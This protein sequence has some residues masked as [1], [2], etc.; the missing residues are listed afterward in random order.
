MIC[1]EA[2]KLVERLADG[3]A[4]PDERAAVEGHVQTCESCRAHL[5][6]LE[7]IHGAARQMG[8]SLPQPDE[9]Y[10]NAFPERVLERVR[11]VRR[12]PTAGAGSW[13]LGSS[14][15]LLRFGALAATVV[16]GV[17]LLFTALRDDLLLPAPE[18]RV[19]EGRAAVRPA[20]VPSPSLRPGS[21]DQD[22]VDAL[23]DRA[24]EQE[25]SPAVTSEASPEEAEPAFEKEPRP[26]SPESE[27]V[28]A[29]P[30]SASP[31][32]SRRRLAE[33]PRPEAPEES[34]EQD[35]LASAPAPT[36]EP[37]GAQLAEAPA[38]GRASDPARRLEVAPAGA[39]VAREWSVA[40]EPGEPLD[41]A[42]ETAAEAVVEFRRL[43]AAHS[44]VGSRKA[45]EARLDSP[46]PL[47]SPRT[48]EVWRSY[49]ER[50]GS[51]P[52]V[53]DAR[54][55][56][57][58]CSVR[59]HDLAPE[60]GSRERALSDLEA[61]LAVEGDTERAAEMKALAERLRSGSEP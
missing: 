6:A 7:S 43:V 47:L 33:T 16:I 55:E 58:W 3:E 46:Q 15:S 49:L 50:F 45:G 38:P 8:G 10:W 41:D 20:P 17:T 39:T 4:G 21:S 36:K 34:P 48:C 29:G 12:E 56:L 19:S 61:F 26:A 9:A 13:T 22:R 60:S 23:A 32:D 25:R 30:Q 31:R 52:R 40:T 53:A 27:G 37:A 18:P 28:A 24:D 44:V 57:A 59:R 54:Y 42:A 51:G 2:T 35:E 14:S 5:S 1:H 11:K